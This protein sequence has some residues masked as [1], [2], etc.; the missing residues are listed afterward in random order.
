MK[1][2]KTDITVILPVHELNDETKTLLDLA[3]KSISIQ[4]TKPDEVLIV[5]PK[6]SEAA[7]YMKK[8]TLESNVRIFEHDDET[9]FCT[10]VNLGVA[11]SKTEWVSVL[12]Y[13]DEYSKIWF[14]NVLKYREAFPEVG[15]FMPIIV[16]TNK[17]GAFMGF[18][19]EA[20]WANSFSDELGI[21]DNNALLD[22]QG[23]N[24]DGMVIRKSIIE[25]FG[26]FKS[27]I[28]LT[29][30]YEFLLRMTFK[31]VRIMVIPRFAYKH[32]NQRPGSLF[33]TYKT[34]LDAIET[35][36]WLSQAKKE[37][38]FDKDRKITYDAQTT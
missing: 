9:D 34:E 14:T 29:F 11:E 17:D 36:W 13:D 6:N 16:D 37:Y 35:K 15:L 32:M 3:L 18:T 4:D 21:L 2:N 28:K 24:T 7:K 25:E 22:Y 12:E 10:Q 26:G 5:T 20:V 1:K 38:Y 27:N 19:N 31:D 23:F 33:A 30:P 8:L